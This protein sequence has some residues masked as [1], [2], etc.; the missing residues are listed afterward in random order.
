MGSARLIVLMF[1]F[2]VC[3][4]G[5][6]Q[7][8]SAKY[9]ED[10]VKMAVE[11]IG[12]LD[13]CPD[14]ALLKLAEL[15]VE[16]CRSRLAILSVVCWHIIDPVVPDYEIEKDE[17]NNEIAKDRLISLSLVYSSCIR[18]ELLRGIVRKQRETESG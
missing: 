10:E 5:Y 15:E 6:A 14:Q 12:V 8:P 17:N 11:E 1:F 3:Q 16:N 9:T 2:L 13:V 4:F 7:E 18:S